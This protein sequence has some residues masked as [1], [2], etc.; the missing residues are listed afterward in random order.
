MQEDIAALQREVGQL[1]LHVQSLEQENEELKKR[2]PTSETIKS[3][4][5]NQVAASRADTLKDIDKAV[6]ESRKD[7]LADVAKQIE[8]LATETNAQFEK[9]R[10]YMGGASVS[11]S[12]PAA[13]ASTTPPPK[14]DKGQVYKVIKGDSLAKIAKK[15]GVPSSEIL[16]AN[17]QLNNNASLIREGQDL[18]IPQKD[19]A[20]ATVQ[21]LTAPP[22]AS[23]N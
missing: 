1:T 15:F 6:T 17:P 13:P 10:K 14:F 5:Q 22:A 12:R 3:L 7:I 11:V 4:V 21:G 8:A 19:G 16:L 23:G 2:V 9:L 20:P 18:F